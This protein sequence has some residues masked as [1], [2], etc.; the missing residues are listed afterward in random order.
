MAAQQLNTGMKETL[1][2]TGVTINM[3]ALIAPGAAIRCI[4]NQ[5]IGLTDFYYPCSSKYH[6]EPIH[7]SNEHGSYSHAY[8]L[9]NPF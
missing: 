9:F 4:E 5:D 7:L 1:G 8:Y 3:M 6:R 2:L